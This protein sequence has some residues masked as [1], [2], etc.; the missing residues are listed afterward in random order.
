MDEKVQEI[1]KGINSGIWRYVGG[2]RRKTRGNE[3]ASRICNFNLKGSTSGFGYEMDEVPL[4]GAAKTARPGLR[5]SIAAMMID[6]L[7][8]RPERGER[9]KQKRNSQTQ[10]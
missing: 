9:D 4:I 1:A 2:S 3:C 8:Y 7:C 6:I 10:S 5:R